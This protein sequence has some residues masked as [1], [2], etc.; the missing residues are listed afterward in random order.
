M[1]IGMKYL[2]S[3][4]HRVVFSRFFEGED[5]LGSIASTA[6]QNDADSGFFL[7]IGTL[8][9]A[10]L[11]FYKEGKYVPIEKSGPLEI[12]SCTGNISTKEDGELVV[13]G[14]VVVGDSR[15][16]AFG[17]HVL[18]GCL[19]DVTA[20]LVL[21]EVEKGSLARRFE[22]ERNLYLWALGRG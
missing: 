4:I 13:H 9:K 11:G 6:K 19:V 12:V 3:K 2:D 15:G 8:K 16:D 14:H 17:G 18:P 10:I 22:P 5:L 20:E 1:G 21:V 7:L